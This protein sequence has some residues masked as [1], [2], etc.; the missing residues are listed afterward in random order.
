MARNVD[1]A[2]LT[3]IR[4]KNTTKRIIADFDPDTGTLLG[5]DCYRVQQLKQNG[6][7]LQTRDIIP[8]NLSA[9]ELDAAA[10]QIR[11]RIESI[12]NIADAKE[13]ALGING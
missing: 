12:D 9:A 2:D 6:T 8:I 1:S 11:N 10:T 5:L 4:R 13:I 7:V 3:N